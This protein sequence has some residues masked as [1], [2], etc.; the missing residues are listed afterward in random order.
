MTV[1]KLT[2]LV[3]EGVAAATGILVGAAVVFTASLVIEAWLS[4]RNAVLGLS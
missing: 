2:A 4:V 3:A 1:I